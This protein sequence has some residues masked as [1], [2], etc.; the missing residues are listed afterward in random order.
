MDRGMNAN[1]QKPL[2]K[3]FS[4][5]YVFGAGNKLWKSIELEIFKE[6]LQLWYTKQFQRKF[7]DSVVFWAG[8]GNDPFS[9]RFVQLL[10]CTMLVFKTLKI[11]F[12]IGKSGAPNAKWLTPRVQS[13]DADTDRRVARK[14]ST[15][16]HKE[17]KLIALSTSDSNN[18][19]Q[20]ILDTTRKLKMLTIEVFRLY[21]VSEGKK[22]SG[23]LDWKR[24]TCDCCLL[25]KKYCKG[26]IWNILGSIIIQKKIN[27]RRK[28]RCQD[29]FV[30]VQRQTYSRNHSSE[31]CTNVYNLPGFLA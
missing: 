23:R 24:K 11:F 9:Q 22:M 4:G 5:S 6:K 26:R 30:H 14:L 10:R 17:E 28:W 12:N 13:V 15:W 21:M 3:K 8:S 1:V 20:S 19:G 16:E 29:L 7:N 18:L 31:Y 2:W 27:F 25:Q